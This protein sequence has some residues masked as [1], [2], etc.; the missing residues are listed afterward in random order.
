ML[1]KRFGLL[2]PRAQK[3]TNPAKSV[4]TCAVSG[5]CRRQLA[6]KTKN[7]KLKL[8]VTETQTGTTSNDKLADDRKTQILLNNAANV[9]NRI[10]KQK[11]YWNHYYSATGKVCPFHL[12]RLELEFR[13]RGSARSLL[14][15]GRPSCF[16]TARGTGLAPAYD[17]SSRSP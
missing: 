9:T 6:S 8:T 7:P 5:D 4:T 12:A 13:S 15:S 10:N 17:T 11:K 1:C 16:H 3:Q 2:I 14:F